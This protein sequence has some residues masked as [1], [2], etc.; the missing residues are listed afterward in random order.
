MPALYETA[1]GFMTGSF[2]FK[3]GLTV[4]TTNASMAKLN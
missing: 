3:L 1:A 4:L 2:N